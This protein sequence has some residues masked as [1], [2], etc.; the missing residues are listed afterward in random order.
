MRNILNNSLANATLRAILIVIVLVTG[1]KGRESGN[2]FLLV[3][4]SLAFAFFVY[5]LII[6]LASEMIVITNSEETKSVAVAHGQTTKAAKEQVKWLVL[7]LL[8]VVCIA[9]IVVRFSNTPATTQADNR[10]VANEFGFVPL[11]QQRDLSTPSSRLVGHWKNGDELK[12]QTNE[13][14]KWDEGDGKRTLINNPDYTAR[15]PSVDELI[16]RSDRQ[17]EQRL[18]QEFGKASDAVKQQVED[19]KRSIRSKHMFAEANLK[20]QWDAEKDPQRRQVLLNQKK[21]MESQ[22]LSRLADIDNKYLS[23]NRALENTMKAEMQK[24][25]ALNA[26][27]DFE[28]QLIRKHTAEGRFR[29]NALALQAEYKALGVEVVKINP[30]S[31]YFQYNGIRWSQ[32]I[33][34][35]SSTQCISTIDSRIL[36]KHP[37]VEDIVKYASPA[38]VTIILYDDIGDVLGF[39]SGFFIGNGKILTNA[40]V[41]EGAYSAEVRSL[42][43]TYEDVTIDKRDDDVDLAVL[44]VQRVGEPIISLADDTDLDAGQ[45]VLVIGNPLGFERTVSDGL[46]SAIKDSAGVHE[47][48]FTA[49]ISGGSSGGPMLNTDGLVI[50]ITYAGIDEGQNLN[51]AIGIK[52]LKWF[53]KTPDH[54]EQLKK[55]GSYIPGRV[56][57]YWAK[58]IVIGIV[59]LAIGVIS[60]I[61]ILKRLYRLVTTSFRRKK[62]PVAAVPKEEQA[63]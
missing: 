26:Q 58:N 19:D 60:L 37:S 62:I 59:M 45:R 35:P 27:R 57:R 5:L 21:T 12:Q 56:V 47:I 7:A 31:V 6:R 17:T 32:E 8:A 29:S 30:D 34:E 4:A 25:K 63:R 43:K 46:I 44:S 9:I 49:P 3:M 52:T 22:T 20:R 50:G 16:R 51:F 53:L 11:Q 40:H 15:V 42:R 38:V 28:I 24:M 54:P 36:P 23:Q 13:R 55:A 1:I 10:D 18:Q 39:G 2:V 41:V 61:Y 33:N 14:L 48:Q